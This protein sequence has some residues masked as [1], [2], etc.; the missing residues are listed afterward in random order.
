M[1]VKAYVF[2]P[3]LENDND[4]TALIVWDPLDEVDAGGTVSHYSVNISGGSANLVS[5]SVTFTTILVTWY[6][7]FPLVIHI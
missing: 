7:L 6:N 5:F 2:R 3:S 1:N 4:I